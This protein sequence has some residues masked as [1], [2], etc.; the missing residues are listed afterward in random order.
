M[1]TEQVVIISAPI[2]KVWRLIDDPEQVRKWLPQITETKL[3]G[4][5]KDRRVGTKFS[6]TFKQGSTSRSYTGVIKT[7]APEKELEVNI[8]EQSFLSNVRYQL[9]GAAGGG[10]EVRMNVVV[11]PANILLRA[12][13]ALSG[14]ILNVAVKKLLDRLKAAAE[15]GD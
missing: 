5:A 14:P 3:V 2:S 1:K 12:A 9:A 13:S 6:Q 10:T 7:Y 15:R 8:T 4:D 11:R